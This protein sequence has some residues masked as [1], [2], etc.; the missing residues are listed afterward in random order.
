[1]NRELDPATHTGLISYFNFNQGIASGNNT[2]L[3]T[4][5][6]MTGNNN[7]SMSN[8]SMSGGSSNF[9]SQK[10]SL[11]ILPLSWLSFTAQKEDNKVL[12]KWKTA[13]EINVNDFL[14][15]R[16][17]NGT[18]WKNIGVLPSLKNE[19]SLSYYSFTDILPA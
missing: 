17:S 19:G 8:F 13:N 6:D 10:S 12:L 14:V 2:G 7:G 3:I 1:M 9:V 18:E 5:I 16:S 11:V 15:Q 4:A